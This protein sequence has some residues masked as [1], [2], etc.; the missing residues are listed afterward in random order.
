MPDSRERM[1]KMMQQ[2]MEESKQ[3]KFFVSG[4]ESLISKVSCTS[5]DQL[6]MGGM[7]LAKA[8]LPTGHHIK[9]AMAYADLAVKVELVIV[10]TQKCNDDNIA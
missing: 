4:G 3:S 9:E 8:F 1:E 6:Q 10:R 5:H 2:Q 7:L